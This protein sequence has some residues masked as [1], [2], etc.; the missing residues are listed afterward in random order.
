MSAMTNSELTALS[1]PDFCLDH[2]S[3]R[4][5]EYSHTPDAVFALEKDGNAALF[6]LKLTGVVRL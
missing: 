4:G 3:K 6:F 1:P 2:C 5:V